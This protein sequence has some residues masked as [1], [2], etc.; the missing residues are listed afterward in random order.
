MRRALA[1]DSGAHVGLDFS[2]RKVLAAYEAIP[3]LG[4]GLVA[5]MDLSELRAPFLRAAIVSGIG[6]LLVLLLGT[7]LF[8]RI[9]SPLVENLEQT[10][11]RLTEAQRVARLGNWERDIATGDGWWSEETYKIFG[12]EPTAVPP[13]LEVFL[14]SVHKEDRQK[15]QT[16][17]DKCLAAQ[18]PFAVD[19]RIT[20]PD[21]SPR[22]IHARGTWRLD[23]SGQPERISGTI[24]I[25]PDAENICRVGLV[26]TIRNN[27]RLIRVPGD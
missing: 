7:A 13:R 20:R 23:K 17:I 5:K 6:A 1:G 18:E 21:G 27:N 22:T 12:L 2:D 15:V 24:Q 9:S 16:A 3:S 4:I 14:E 25:S 26:Q 11:S 8:Q 19:F 10:V